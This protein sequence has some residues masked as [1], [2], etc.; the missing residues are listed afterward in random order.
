MQDVLRPGH[1]RGFS[2]WGGDEAIE[3]LAEMRHRDRP[4][5]GRAA[6]RQIELEQL[7]ARTLRVE[8]T[9]AMAG[10]P[11]Q[12]ATGEFRREWLQTTVLIETKADGLLHVERANG[13]GGRVGE[14]P[15]ALL[16]MPACIGTARQWV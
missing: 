2:R 9:P 13:L 1:E 8:R 16:G 14:R 10:L 4:A 3:A 7:R 15:G 11:M 12:V 6:D 5:S